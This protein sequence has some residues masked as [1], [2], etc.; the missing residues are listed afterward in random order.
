MVLVKLRCHVRN[1][2]K[3]LA[4][5]RDDDPPGSLTIAS[6]RRGTRPFDWSATLDIYP[7]PHHQRGVWPWAQNGRWR[8]MRGV[9]RRGRGIDITIALR[10]PT[11]ALRPA[12]ERAWAT[13]RTQDETITSPSRGVR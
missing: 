7:C 13:G 1:C 12:I 9:V 2:R 8:G 5:I 10:L 6:P 4:S 3:V 11:E